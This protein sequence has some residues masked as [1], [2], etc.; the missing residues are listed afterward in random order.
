M[1][2]NKVCPQC[3]AI[4]YKVCKSCE[5]VFRAKRKAEHT[6]C[7]SDSG[8]EWVCKTCDRALKH[9]VMPLQAKANGLQF[10]EIHLS[11]LISMHWN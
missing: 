6:R 7:V 1:P 5:H 9:G 2:P 8:N 3:K 10:F 11:S 4:R